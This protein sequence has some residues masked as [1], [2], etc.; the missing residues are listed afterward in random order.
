MV[1]A[2]ADAYAHF[3]VGD[4]DARRGVE[5]AAEELLG[6]G[7][8]ETGERAC[9]GAVEGVGYQGEHEVEVDLYGDGG[10]GG[11]HMQVS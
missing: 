5:K 10:I 2:P 11:V 8:L 9:E 1:G 3:G 6:F 7:G 4:G